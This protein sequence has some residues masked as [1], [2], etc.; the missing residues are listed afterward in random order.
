ML[1]RAALDFPSSTFHPWRIGIDC[2]EP[3]F[4][5][6][7]INNQSK[8]PPFRNDDADVYYEEYDYRRNQPQ[9]MRRDPF[10]NLH[11]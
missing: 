8:P 2:F 11:E 10:Q 6:E 3:L 5:V 7:D 1:I 4:G 9:P